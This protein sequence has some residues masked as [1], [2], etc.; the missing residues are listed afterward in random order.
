MKR[1]IFQIIGSILPNSYF[2]VIVTKVIYR[3][4]LKGICAPL[5]NCYA[6]PLATVSCPIGTLQHF[7]AIAK[8]P[9][10]LI[11][12]LGLIGLAVGRMA[13]GWICPFGFFQDLMAKIKTKKFRLPSY[14]GYMRYVTL[15][16]LAII[17]PFI[18][19]VHWFSKLCPWGALEASIPWGLWNPTDPGFLSLTPENTPVR[20]LISGSYYLKLGIL[21]GFLGLMIF[22]KRPFCFLAC[23][24]GAIYSL[25][26]KISIIRL[27]VDM[28]SCTKCNKCLK[29]CPAG[30]KVYEEPNS[31]NCIRCLE[32]T[33]CDKVKLYSI[34]NKHPMTR[35][36]NYEAGW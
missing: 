28:E 22:F 17:I 7:M 26:N 18:T 1:R 9:Y 16:L 14:L 25:F 3:G 30:L 4:Q 32:C 24:L 13:C 19:H 6:C 20:D 34:F 2:Q 12:Y 27:G 33:K 11:G 35:K 29:N 15:V 10:Y 36:D 23:P 5:F 21:A 31:P 8:I